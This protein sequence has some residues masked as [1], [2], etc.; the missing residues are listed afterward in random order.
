MAS[1]GNVSAMLNAL[2]PAHLDCK[3]FILNRALG[4]YRHGMFYV[5]QFKI[6]LKLILLLLIVRFIAFA[7]APERERLPITIVVRQTR[8][9]LLDAAP[10][11]NDP[12]IMN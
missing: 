5:F 9:C 7:N 4:L 6:A 1:D 11:P 8:H 12:V 10:I 2:F 3:L